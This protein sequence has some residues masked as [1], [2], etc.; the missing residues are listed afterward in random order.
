M[1]KVIKIHLDGSDDEAYKRL[2]EICE[3]KGI[4]LSEDE[5]PSE[6]F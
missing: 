2:L 6:D 3:E 5:E 4:I 1:E